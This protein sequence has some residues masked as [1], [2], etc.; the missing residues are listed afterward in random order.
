MTTPQLRPYQQN[1]ISRIFYQFQSHRRV[2]AQAPTGSGKSVIFGAIA[3][4]FAAKGCRV[5]CLAHR[6]ELIIQGASHL[7]NWTPY[8]VGIIKVGFPFE[9][10]F[11]VQFASIQ[12]II[13][14]L[15]LVG[16]YD[17]IVVDEAHHA[18]S[19]TYV[20][21]LDRYPNAKILGLTATP[22]RSDGKGFDRL[23]D[24]LECGV[25][26]AE[27]IESGYLSPYRLFADPRSMNT[28]GVRIKTHIPLVEE[29]IE[30]LK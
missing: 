28:Q 22:I 15:D 9:P 14:R 12:T 24:C 4:H 17:L 16:D 13:N 20:T 21:I 8:P 27:L 19:E 7:Q 10:L 18:T 29:A 26:T 5:L 6:E 23:F 30:E 11:P 2:M 3:S 25:T 1:L